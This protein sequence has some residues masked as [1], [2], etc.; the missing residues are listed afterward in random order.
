MV[1]NLDNLLFWKYSIAG[2]N[3]IFA[4]GRKKVRGIRFRILVFFFLNILASWVNINDH[5]L[6]YM[7]PA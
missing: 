4:V 2:W 7:I 5:I 6:I 3:S 1:M